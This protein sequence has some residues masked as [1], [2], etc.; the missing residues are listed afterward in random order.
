MAEKIEVSK[1]DKTSKTGTYIDIEKKDGKFYAQV[2][3]VIEGERQPTRRAFLDVIGQG[4]KAFMTIKAPMRE[5]DENKQF[6]TRARA[7]DGK[8]LNAK[9]AEVATEAE[10]AREYVYKTQRDDAT[11]V[12]YGQIA[13]MNVQNYKSDKVT[14]NAFTTFSVKLFTDEEALAAERHVY[15]LTAVRAKE[16]EAGIF[17]EGQESEEC[18][19]ISDEIRKVRRET[20]RVESFFINKGADVLREMGFS[21]RDREPKAEPTPS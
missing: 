19:A 7:K 11:K 6:L 3:D 1:I 14:L 8:F 5:V 17:V 13:T 21:I 2:T 9:G 10:A 18:K 4:D 12:V 16:K 20:G 15:K